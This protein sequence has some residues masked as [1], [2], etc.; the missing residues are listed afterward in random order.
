MKDLYTFDTCLNNAQH[1]YDLICES[2]D[3][4]FKHIGMNYAKG[5]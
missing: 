5:K 1:T 2:Y 3:N 4:I